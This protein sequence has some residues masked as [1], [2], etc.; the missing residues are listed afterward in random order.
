MEQ[1]EQFLNEMGLYLSA[2]DIV[3]LRVFARNFLEKYVKN[4]NEQA[5]EIEIIDEI[6]QQ[7]TQLTS[8]SIAEKLR[9]WVIYYFPPNTDNSSEFIWAII[10]RR[11]AGISNNSQPIK[12]LD[13]SEDKLNLIVAAIRENIGDY[14]V[15]D[16]KIETVERLPRSE[17]EQ[18]MYNEYGDDG[19]PLDIIRDVIDA[20]RVRKTWHI[21]ASILNEDDLSKFIEWGKLDAK[22]MNIPD[23]LIER[24]R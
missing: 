4:N 20:Q 24:L 15:L 8:G 7:I 19:T 5:A 2:D 6:L 12:Y 18:Y 13:L 3:E 23:N 9:K 21:I 1:T 16:R 22:E 14:N 11:L 17:W 10:L